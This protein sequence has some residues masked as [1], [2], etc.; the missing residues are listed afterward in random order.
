MQLVQWSLAGVLAALAWGP[1]AAQCSRALQV[2]VA[3]LGL[4]VT[5]SDDGIGGVYPEILR[6][7]AGCEVVFTVVPRARQEAMFEA[8]R[9]D[10]L[11]PASKTPRRDEWGH[12]VPLIQ[13]RATLVSLAGER[14]PLRS[15]QELRERR[16]LRVAVVRGFDYGEAYQ[17]L[18][19]DLR[20]QGRLATEADATSVGRL[21]A[22][23]MADLTI[24]APSILIGA[25]HGDARVRPLLERLR[26]EPVE[27]LPWTDSGLYVSRS[28]VSEADRLALSAALDRSARG[29]AVWRAFLRHYPPGSLSES[30]RPR[31]D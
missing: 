2:P 13:A 8:G 29:G 21:L 5:V 24:M 4:S 25:L 9:S 30:I 10:L 23:G 31:R 7:M 16:E 17:A 27:E 11:V 22:A 20:A 3:P 14:A 12:F 6:G 15:L 28:A 18:L 1:A 26:V 19:T